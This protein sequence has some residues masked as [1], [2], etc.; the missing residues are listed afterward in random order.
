[1]RQYGSHLDCRATF[2]IAAAAIPSRIMPRPVLL[3]LIGAT[4]FLALGVAENAGL[5][6]AAGWLPRTACGSASAVV[7]VGLAASEGAGLIRVGRTLGCWWQRPT[8]R[9][10]THTLVLGLAA[11]AMA[12]ARLLHLI[13]D[14]LAMAACCSAAVTTGLAFHQQVEARLALPCLASQHTAAPE[15]SFYHVRHAIQDRVAG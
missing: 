10:R 8:R 14:G 13:P 6:V 2:G 15:E 1:M 4:A 11:R 7:I 5:L 3:T 9:T 12:E